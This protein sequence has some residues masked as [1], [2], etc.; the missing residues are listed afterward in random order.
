MST[1]TVMTRAPSKTLYIKDTEKVDA[2][3]LEDLFKD[4]T[5]MKE[6]IAR[7]QVLNDE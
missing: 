7:S 5:G 2:R 6:V 1:P 4:Q 3:D